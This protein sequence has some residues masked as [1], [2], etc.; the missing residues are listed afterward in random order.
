MRLV[1]IDSLGVISFIGKSQDF[2]D[3]AAMVFEMVHSLPTVELPSCV[4]DEE[5]SK[6]LMDI[7][8][9]EGEEE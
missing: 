2:I 5:A 1:D 8:S 9:K 4:L 6:A 7:I 3:G